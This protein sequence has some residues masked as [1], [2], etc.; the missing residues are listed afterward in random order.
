MSEDTETSPACAALRWQGIPVS[1]QGTAEPVPTRMLVRLGVLLGVTLTHRP[2][3]SLTILLPQ[4]FDQYGLGLHAAL[5]TPQ[6]QAALGL[7]A[8]LVSSG[9][10]LDYVE[11]DME[12]MREHDTSVK[13]GG[14]KGRLGG[15][16]GGAKRVS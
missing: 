11:R 2:S 3:S 16:G 9:N 1:A 12:I 10:S 6:L 15:V 8:G 13:V 7:K 4:G 14:E 5:P